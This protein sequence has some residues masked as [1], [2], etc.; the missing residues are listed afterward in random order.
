MIYFLKYKYRTKYIS[1]VKKEEL[2][3]NTIYMYATIVF[4]VRE[5]KQS[6][7]FNVR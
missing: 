5:N 2:L 4:Y 7:G 6:S 3:W 1:F